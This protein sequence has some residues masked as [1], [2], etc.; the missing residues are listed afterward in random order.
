ME[1]GKPQLRQRGRAS[2]DALANINRALAGISKQID[3]DIDTANLSLD[4]SAD[5]DTL[6]EEIES[7]LSGSAAH[8]T[9]RIVREWHARNH[10]PLAVAA[11]DEIRAELE[12]VLAR[13]LEGPASLTLNPDMAE[14]DY[15]QNVWFHRTEGGWDGHPYMGYVHGEIVHKQMVDRIFPGGI[16]KQRRFVA[17][18]APHEAYGK[19][20]DKGC[21]SGHFTQ[22]LTE[23]YPDAKITGVDLS[24]RMLEHAYRTANDSGWDWD[25]HQ[26][27]AES[28]GLPNDTFDLVASYILFHELPAAAISAVLEEA[29]RVLAP[30]GD[31]L[32]SDVTRYADLG[33]LEKW[34]AD[35]AARLGGE[36]YW[37]ESANLDLAQLAKNAGFED[38]R[39]ERIY[40][41]ILFGKKPV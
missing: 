28:T 19:I 16:F 22:A 1:L 41:H 6:T 3:R 38:V 25:L 32:M 23:S 35:S 14:P 30:G 17:E 39:A 13:T 11:I 10:G 37:R 9:Q 26:V 24:A 21:S 12:P 18:S 36:P 34:R 31:L 15:W 2:V 7:A 4:P 40:P 5:I 20:L 8:G 33:P 29:Y 27:P